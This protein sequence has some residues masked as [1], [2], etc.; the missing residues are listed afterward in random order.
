MVET[1]AT[2]HHYHHFNVYVYQEYDEI[3]DG[4]D[5]VHG[6][7]NVLSIIQSGCMGMSQ[8]IKIS[9]SHIISL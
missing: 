2:K 3:W 5:M 7:R 4:F 6:F 9:L 1:T 8:F